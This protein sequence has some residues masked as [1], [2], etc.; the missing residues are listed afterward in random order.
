MEN[1]AHA[2]GPGSMNVCLHVWQWRWHWVGREHKT[3]I[4]IERWVYVFFCFI[5][6]G[7]IFRPSSAGAPEEN[8]GDPEDNL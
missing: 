4:E 6:F 7:V 2:I 8:S 5:F 1:S 3:P